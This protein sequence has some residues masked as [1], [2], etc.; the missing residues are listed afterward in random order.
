MKKPLAVLFTRPYQ[1]HEAH[2]TSGALR[3]VFTGVGSISPP[4]IL[5]MDAGQGPARCCWAEALTDTVN[6]NY[7]P[8]SAQKQGLATVGASNWKFCEFI[9]QGLFCSGLAFLPHVNRNNIS[10]RV[11]VT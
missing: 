11:L 4:A 2:G 5:Q 10:I 6:G 3:S 7:S 9:Y 1:S 8:G